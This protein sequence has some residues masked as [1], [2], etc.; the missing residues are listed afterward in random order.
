MSTTVNVTTPAS[1]PTVYVTQDGDVTVDISYNPVG[2]TSGDVYG[3]ASATDNAIAR[4]DGTSGKVIQNSGI[5][6]ADGANGTLSGTNSGDVTLDST[7]TDIL[8]ITGQAISADDQ[9][10][11]KLVFWDESQ[12]KLTSL[13]VGSGL[14]ITDTT[15]TATGSGDVVGPASSTDNAL[16]RFDGTTGK[17]VQN[18][19]ITESDTGDL[20]NVNSIAMDT[21]PSGSLSTQG[22]MMW[23]NGE[24]T[25]DIQLNGFALHVGEH[26]VYHV[27]NSTGSTI[28][29]GVPVMLAGTDGNSGKLLVQPWNGTG[30]STY[31]MGLAAEELSNGEEGFVIAFGKLRGIQTNGGNY[32]ESWVNGEIIYASTTT[33]YLTKTQPAAPN[34]HIQVLAVVSAHASNGT[35]FIRPTLG[36]NIKDDEGVTITSLSSGQILVANAAG[37][38]FENKSVSGDATLANTG[39][40]T[41]VNTA[42]TPG[43]YTN[44]NITVDSKGRITSAANGTVSGGTVTSVA[45]SGTDGIQVDSGSPITTSGTIQLGVDAATMK[46]TLDLAG[47][48]T[49]D[50]NVFST[51]AV[52][53]QS[54]VVADS[55]SD[56]LTL[57]AG[58][59]V[60]I[61]TNASTDSITINATDSYT[62]DV[63]GP[64]SAVNGDVALFD[65]TTGKLIKD[66]GA[67]LTTG[68]NGSADSGKLPI[69]NSEGGLTLGSYSE[70]SG[71]TL[72]TYKVG[73]GN[74]IAVGVDAFGQGIYS[75][76]NGSSSQCFHSHVTA[77]ATGS[78]AGLDTDMTGGTGVNWSIGS[79]TNPDGFV[80]YHRERNTG[81]GVAHDRFT[82]DAQGDVTWYKDGTTISSG[83]D[84]T[85]L[86]CATPNGTNTLTLPAATGTVALTSNLSSYLPLSGGTLLGNLAISTQTASTIAAFD[87]SKNVSSLS[88]ATYPD[89]TELSYVKGV[90]SAIQT[91]LNGKQSTLTTGN[92]TTTTTGLSITG[93]TGAVIGSG[94]TVNVQT[95][96]GSQAGLLSSTDWTTFNSKQAAITFG[97]NVL[98]SLA[99]NMGASGTLAILG[100][101]TFTGNQTAP[102]FL[103]NQTA[104][105]P[106]FALS[107]ATNCGVG[108]FSDRVEAWVGGSVVANFVAGEWQPGSANINWG[109]NTRLYGNSDGTGRLVERNGTS[110]QTFS[111]ANTWTSFTNKEELEIGWVSNSNIGKI[112]TIKGSGGGTARA[113]YLGTDSTDRMGFEATTFNAFM[114][115]SAGSYGSGSGVLFLGNATTAPTTNPTG[116][117]ILYVESGALKY[118]GSSGTVTTLGAA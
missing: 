116:G 24:E 45:I 29:K 69:L 85:T 65:G 105:R 75:E 2:T 60:T 94:A 40:L 43:S 27:K 32:G 35:L 82:I 16:V 86:S 96:S 78:N 88:T 66:S 98:T 13:T 46:T 115:A 77:S 92:L 34:P 1:K 89:L 7:V 28:A 106:Q 36:S 39:A 97:T 101:N 117:G 108:V 61:T 68:G 48:N 9:G 93:G 42:V 55:T 90:T 87:A 47:T 30:P 71:N 76:V 20:A 103:V 21:T 59:N 70:F 58:T 79:L 6:I 51:F 22:Q 25:L 33:G 63:V 72:N 67:A 91:Q 114:L 4:F 118:R 81:T 14:S 112:R 113:L 12:S 44:T 11:D 99:N 50:Q 64:A 102:Q 54:N 18:G 53:G 17:L 31:F 74:C 41:L 23:N 95:A 49:G 38:V 5:T 56:T 3:P 26:V 19:Q 100:A 110:A 8:T 37:T 109:S 15:I 52:A 57:V 111:I 84:K 104:T 83:S 10:S 62:G 107:T 80:V 73:I